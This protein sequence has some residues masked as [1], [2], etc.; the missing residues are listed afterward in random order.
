M[1]QI[2]LYLPK[3]NTHTNKFGE[4]IPGSDSDIESL[5]EYIPAEKERSLVPFGAGALSDIESDG[6][7]ETNSKRKVISFDTPISRF[8]GL[9]LETP[10]PPGCVAQKEEEEM[11]TKVEWDLIENLPDPHADEYEDST[12]S[13]L[14]GEIKFET[15]INLSTA[16][17]NFINR[18]AEGKPDTIQFKV[19]QIS[20][21][22]TA[23]KRMPQLHK[24]QSI[25]AFNYFTARQKKL[26]RQY[27]T[28]SSTLTYEWEI[29]G[30]VEPYFIDPVTQ[31]IL[32]KGLV[33]T[34]TECKKP[35]VIDASFG[36]FYLRVVKDNAVSTPYAT[37]NL[38]DNHDRRI[39][40]ND[41]RVDAHKRSRSSP[42]ADSCVSF[43]SA[44]QQSQ[45]P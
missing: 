35:E 13:I 2:G 31:D 39:S 42:S 24:N 28:S 27:A 26:N 32:P 11:A 23:R 16:V 17:L 44:T 36:N 3:R 38:E 8:A 34:Q 19:E 22:R 40:V 7:G 25:F 1:D 37:K 4:D 5:E 41:V 18:K 43:H 21:M 10:S 14:S 33:F 20:A 45:T 29:P 12:R 9:R 6:S 30:N 15:G